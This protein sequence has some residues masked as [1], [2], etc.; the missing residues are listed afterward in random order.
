MELN[1]FQYKDAIHIGYRSCK[2]DSLLEL[3]FVLSIEDNWYFLREH[4][5]IFYDPKTFLPTNYIRETTRKY[6]PDFLIR[7]KRNNKAYLIELKPREFRNE[8]QTMSRKQ[9]ADNYIKSKKSDWIYKVVYDDE[10][11]LSPEQKE[12]LASL[13][14][15]I[16]AF[17]FKCHF[18]HLDKKWNINKRNYFK[19]IPGARKGISPDAY[20]KF[21]KYGMVSGN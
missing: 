9:V 13:R 14:A 17:N 4:I 10:I 1:S 19:T 2:F 18:H 8:I 15:G 16:N 7:D 11:I 20:A 3:K 12:K 5:V 21:V 6:T